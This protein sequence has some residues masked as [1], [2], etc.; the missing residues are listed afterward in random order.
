MF[1]FS[2]LDL[3]SFIWCMSIRKIRTLVVIWVIVINPT[4]GK[5]SYMHEVL[6]RLLCTHGGLVDFEVI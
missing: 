5:M 4:V 2:C 6:A 1:P 3:G